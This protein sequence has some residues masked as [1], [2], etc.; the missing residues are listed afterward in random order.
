[1]LDKNELTSSIDSHIADWSDT[2]SLPNYTGSPGF[3]EKFLQGLVGK[4]GDLDIEDTMAS[5]RHLIGQGIVGEGPGKQ[6]IMG[7]SHGGFVTAHRQS[8]SSTQNPMKSEESPMR[9]HCAVIGKYPDFFSAA[10]LRNPVISAGDI[11]N[12][13]IPD[14]YFSE[15][16]YEYPMSSSRS[17]IEKH[18]KSSSSAIPPLVSVEMFA[19][20][21]AMSPIAAVDAIKTPVLLLM[22]AADRRVA[23]S[24][25]IAFYHALKA[26]YA[27]SA[28]K[29]RRSKL[30]MLV[31]D[32]EGHPIDGVEASKACAEASAQW[33]AAAQVQEVST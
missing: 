7:G 26:R 6:F 13:D 18:S 3:G 17:F 1:M 8:C 31:F 10:I 2:L 24:Q 23:P 16:G 19:K 21:Q 33:L 5:A 28:A 12:T 27:A 11:S 9:M 30:E 20:V 14:W 4:C 22:G 25:G 32:G 29:D 15:F